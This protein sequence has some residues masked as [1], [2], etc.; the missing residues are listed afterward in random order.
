[1]R[2]G[3]LWTWQWTCTS[4]SRHAGRDRQSAPVRHGIVSVMFQRFECVQ[5]SRRES[6]VDRVKD[7]HVDLQHLRETQPYSL[8]GIVGGTEG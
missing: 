3:M 2:S 5:A 7:E 8:A 4:E 6:V 1:M